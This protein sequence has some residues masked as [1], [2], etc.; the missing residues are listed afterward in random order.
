M[1]DLLIIEFKKS[2]VLQMDFSPYQERLENL[3]ADKEQSFQFMHRVMFMVGG[4][5]LDPRGLSSIPEVVTYFQKLDEHWPYYLFFCLPLEEAF[6]WWMGCT[7][8]PVVGREDGTANYLEVNPERYR[9][10]M[11][12]F[13][14]YANGLAEYHNFPMDEYFERQKEMVDA[15]NKWC[16]GRVV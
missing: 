15:I 6:A 3:I 4:F 12:R 14:T 7:A 5:D 8:F 10:A 16:L 1:K 13:F 11:E 2:D 9:K